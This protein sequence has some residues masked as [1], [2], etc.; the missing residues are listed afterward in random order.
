MNEPA[1]RRVQCASPS[2]LH[3]MSYLEWGARDNPR[4]VVCVHGLTRCGRD[5]DFL[6]RALASGYRVICPDVAGRGESQWL[7][8]PM[9]YAVPTYVADMVSLV[10]RLDAEAIDWVGTS[11]GGL[12]GMAYAAQAGSPIRRLV[13]NDVGPVLTA[14]ALDRIGA[15]VGKAPRFSS[16]DAAE[17]YVRTV[18]APFGPHSDAQWRFLTEHVVR[19]ESDGTL[20]MHY[21]PAIAVPFNARTTREGV[22]LWPLYDMIRCPTLLLRGARS[23]LLTADT[24]L[25]MSGRG[26]KARRVEFQGV[27]HAPTLIHDDQIGAVREFLLGAR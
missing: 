26:P 27:G 16:M 20:R 15:Y 4:I 2:G 5:F 17:N 21:D 18:S 23:D 8:N 9:E 14:A 13:L 6:A 22:D 12:I 19:R 7:R 3:W 10:A 25:A 11:L 24:A 1:R